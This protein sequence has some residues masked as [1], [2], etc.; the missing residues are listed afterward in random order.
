MEWYGLV[1]YGMLCSGMLWSGMLCPCLVVSGL[2]WS[3][4]VLLVWYGLV[5]S[6]MVWC[7]AAHLISQVIHYI[8]WSVTSSWSLFNLQSALAKAHKNEL[9][10][11]SRKNTNNNTN[12]NN[13]YTCMCVSL[14]LSLSNIYIYIYTHEQ[15]CNLQALERSPRRRA[16]ACLTKPVRDRGPVV[17]RNESHGGGILSCRALA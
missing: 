5:R 14:S 6:G 17:R 12:N 7:A 13:M 10:A 1:W 8:R 16:D 15:I 2:V 3:C 9:W 4:L 11:G